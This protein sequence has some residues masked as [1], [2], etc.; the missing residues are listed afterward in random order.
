MS[1]AR[2]HLDISFA[3]APRYIYVGA[4]FVL[5]I[6]AEAWTIVGRRLSIQ[7]LA[8][9]FLVLAIVLNL[10]YLMQCAHAMGPTARRRGARPALSAG[11]PGTL[12][13]LT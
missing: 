12:A 7:R 6:V 11:H 2:A 4:P 13:G 9:A 10:A 3:A 8:P 5:V 1:L